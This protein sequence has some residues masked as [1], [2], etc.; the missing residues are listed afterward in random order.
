MNA[1]DPSLCD[2]PPA[3]EMAATADPSSWWTT[4]NTLAVAAVGLGV[5]GGALGLAAAS[6]KLMKE[7]VEWR[8]LWSADVVDRTNAHAVQF[9]I[10]GEEQLR[11]HSAVYKVVDA[12]GEL[13]AKGAMALGTKHTVNLSQCA[14]G[15]ITLCVQLDGSDAALTLAN[16][17]ILM[18]RA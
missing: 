12:S 6:S 9:A 15:T 16:P 13:Q 4:T 5:V 3:P 8:V 11:G 7:A 17:T 1:G 2:S 18:R 10:E 14:P